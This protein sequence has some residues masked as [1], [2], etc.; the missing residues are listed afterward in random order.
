MI[1]FILAAMV[2]LSGGIDTLERAA[3]AAAIDRAIVVGGPFPGFSDRGTAA[4][5]VAVAYRE[6]GFRNGALNVA[7]EDHCAFQIHL[8]K[9]ARTSA[10]WTGDDLRADVRKCAA[11]AY[12]MLRASA[13]VCPKF[14]VSPYARGVC[15]ATG[16]D[17]DRRRLAARVER[18]VP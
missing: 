5:M 8:P 9:G 6:S 16:W 15:K 17:T 12:R 4:L 2:L 11:V 1:P 14:P 7:S 13:T 18:G 3:L 10:G